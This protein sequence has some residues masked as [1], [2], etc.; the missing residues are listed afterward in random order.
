[1]LSI[2]TVPLYFKLSA[3]MVN[4]V[5]VSDSV[6]ILNITLPVGDKNIG[7]WTFGM[8]LITSSIFLFMIL[9]EGDFPFY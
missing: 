8:F 9:S 6:E 7:I 3:F 4:G 5:T 1:M 2:S